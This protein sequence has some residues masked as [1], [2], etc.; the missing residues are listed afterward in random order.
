[1]LADKIRYKKYSPPLMYMYQNRN[2]RYIS[3]VSSQ[4]RLSYLLLFLLL[5]PSEPLP[6][7]AEESLSVTV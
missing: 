5:L 7:S 1:M 4:T 3:Q 6:L 2:P